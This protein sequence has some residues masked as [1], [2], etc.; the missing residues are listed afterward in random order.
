MRRSFDHEFGQLGSQ[1]S[2][3]GEYWGDHLE[4]VGSQM[5]ARL[6]RVNE[7]VQQQVWMMMMMMMTIMMMIV[8]N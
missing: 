6:R 3:L 2:E 8:L 5:E 1:M 4:T 7:D